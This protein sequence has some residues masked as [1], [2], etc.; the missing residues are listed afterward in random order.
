MQI[1]S[2]TQAI[3]IFTQDAYAKIPE[4]V[5]QAA[6]ERGI[7][8]HE[9]AGQYAAGMWIDEVPDTVTGYFTSFRRWFDSFA[10]KTILVEQLLVHPTLLYQGTPDWAG[11]I[12][13][14]D[15][16]TLLDWKTP[17][18][19]SKAWRLQLA[20]YRAL[21]EKHGH[22]VK[23]VG[24]LQLRKDGKAAKFVE[25]TGSLTDDM[26]IFMAVLTAWRFLND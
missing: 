20:A 16:I 11:V 3:G 24:S 6:Q 12:K 23:R 25:Y 4:D 13:G 21:L 8:L 10:V 19:A 2:V 9:L 26:R 14:D 1:P 18:F 15:V 17:V 22:P 5:L 7:V